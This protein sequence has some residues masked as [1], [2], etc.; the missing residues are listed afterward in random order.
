M[1]DTRVTSQ[2]INIASDTQ[3]TLDL[4]EGLLWYNSIGNKLFI[5]NGSTFREYAEQADIVAIN[6]RI[7]NLTGVDIALT[8][9]FSWSNEID[10]QGVFDD[11][12]SNFYQKYVAEHYAADGKHGPHV[13]IDQTGTGYAL[14]IN[15]TDSTSGVACVDILSHGAQNGAYGL[16][17]TQSAGYPAIEVSRATPHEGPNDPVMRVQEH[18][19]SGGYPDA[20]QTILGVVGETCTNYFCLIGNPPNNAAQDPVGGGVKIHNT[21]NSL[22][23][24]VD[25]IQEGETIA[26]RVNKSS[27]GTVNCVE[28]TNAGTGYDVRG[29]SGNWY[30]EPDGDATFKDVSASGDV[31]AN[32]IATPI[33]VHDSG[34]FATSTLTIHTINHNLGTLPV[35]I[36]VYVADDDGFGSPDT[37]KTECFTQSDL[38]AGDHRFGWIYT[39]NTTSLKLQMATN[40]INQG[41]GWGLDASG[42]A[43]VIVVGIGNIAL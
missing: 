33:A 29:H 42:H 10:V 3:P 28:I 40:F 21:S 14:T 16:R 24:C 18:H 11:V 8:D 15:R 26:L 37:T 32:N 38:T 30:V 2:R 23:P 9:N 35:S 13:E 20:N 27:T 25:V 41:K 4:F 5:Y 6:T 19:L 7:D 1:A 22:T 17:V 31:T 43:R 36:L 34:W 39:I 12:E